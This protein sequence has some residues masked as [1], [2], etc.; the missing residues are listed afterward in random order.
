MSE[1]GPSD[2]S[3]GGPP[4]WPFQPP[5]PFG[6][7]HSDDDPPFDEPAAPADGLPVDSGYSF[8]GALV[9][10]AADESLLLVGEPPLNEA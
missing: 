2:P 9:A 1:G 8:D 5:W 7:P 4:Q 10:A 6:G 3:P